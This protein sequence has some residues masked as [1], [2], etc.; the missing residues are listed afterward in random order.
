M[1][2]SLGYQSVD[3]K[4]IGS[5]TEVPES[6]LAKLMYYLNSVF[7]VIQYDEGDFEKYSDY[8]HYYLLSPEDEIKVLL[9]AGIF[10]PQ[11]MIKLSLFIVDPNLLKPGFSNT[12]FELGNNKIGIH[13]NSEVVIGGVSRKVLKIMACDEAWIVEH[14]YRPMLAY[15]KPE[16]PQAQANYL[17]YEI[18][19]KDCLE[20]NALFFLDFTFCTFC[21][22]YY[23]C[24][25]E[26]SLKC[27]R[28]IGLVNL[29]I[30]IICVILYVIFVVY[31]VH[32]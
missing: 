23:L 2:L 3:V 29:I 1:S 12:F 18:K 10:K 9:L 31:R 32:K 28:I 26:W 14:F 25:C 7:A 11:I 4:L 27:K 16:F 24:G 17:P 19:K 6:P 21:W 13:I 30:I 8:H 15:A 20:S 5:K 22:L